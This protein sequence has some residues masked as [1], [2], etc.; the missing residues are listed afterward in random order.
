MSHTLNEDGLEG[1]MFDSSM[2]LSKQYFTVLQILRI[3]TQWIDDN[4]KDWDKLRNTN[5]NVPI[6]SSASWIRRKENDEQCAGHW[7]MVTESLH[8]RTA[9]LKQ[10]IDRKAEEVR[11][12]RDGVSNSGG[13]KSP[14]LTDS[15]FISNYLHHS[16]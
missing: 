8:L 3:A 9:Q 1:F 5:L 4:L 12:L 2:T 15:C 10:R 6:G 16:C 14:A 11:A 7:D 13:K